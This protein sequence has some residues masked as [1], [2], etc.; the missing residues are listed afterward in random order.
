VINRPPRI[1]N[2]VRITITSDKDIVTARQSGRQMAAES[3]FRSADSTFIAAAISEIGRTIGCLATRG[4]II[5][6]LIDNELKQGVEVVAVAEG[7]GTP[8]LA[9]EM[10][11]GY[12]TSHGLGLSLAGVRQLMD[13]CEVISRGGTRTV[14][15]SR[16]WK[17]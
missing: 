2:E 16:K 10:Q 6:R 13:E 14:V 4:E 5:L 12:S 8:E 7:P 3:G 9:L 1:L 11:D 15:I 17:C